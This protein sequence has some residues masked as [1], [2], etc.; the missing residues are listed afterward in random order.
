MTLFKNHRRLSSFRRTAAIAGCALLLSGQPGCHHLA[1]W[2]HGHAE[3]EA[4]DA[5]KCPQFAVPHRIYVVAHGPIGV[6]GPPQGFVV[7]VV[8]ALNSIPNCNAILL[9]P[10][11]P[12][13]PLPGTPG[14]PAAILQLPDGLDPNPVI[15]Q[16]LI[17]D[18]V[19]IQQFRPMRLSAVLERRTVADGMVISRDHRTWNAPI[20]I[21]PQ[22]PSKFS[23]FILN[24]PPPLDITEQHELSRLSPQT[25]YRNIAQQLAGE[26]VAVPGASAP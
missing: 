5:C 6:A 12:L 7:E 10:N 1:F 19:E 23:R 20:D 18:I 24:H 2:K 22:G 26:L 17:I 21:E 11:A 4:E 3:K 15:E 13:E 16:L 8:A 9:P 14:P 25:F